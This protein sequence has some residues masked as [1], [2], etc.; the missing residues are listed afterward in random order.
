MVSEAPGVHDGQEDA[1][2]HED[3]AEAEAGEGDEGDDGD[4]GGSFSG[5]S[6]G[7]AAPRGPTRL[8]ALQ[9]LLEMM[10]AT[11]NDARHV[12][13]DESGAA[14]EDWQLVCSSPSTIV[15]CYNL[16]RSPSFVRNLPRTK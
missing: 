11:R 14:P 8:L 10:E 13:L 1:D 6:E 7:M 16:R 15:G 2:G 4:D 3:D 9:C 12:M 5:A